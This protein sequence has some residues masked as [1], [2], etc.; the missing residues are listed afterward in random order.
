MRWRS[1]DRFPEFRWE[2]YNTSIIHEESDQN[3]DIV[4][5]EE[6]RRK[7]EMAKESSEGPEDL[8]LC[9]VV[10]QAWSCQKQKLLADEH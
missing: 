5:G 4:I 10:A 1:H 9:N 3:S 8:P 6:D 2:D 7:A